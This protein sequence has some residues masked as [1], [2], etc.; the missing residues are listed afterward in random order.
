MIDFQ[1]KI[2]RITAMSR[3][4]GFAKALGFEL[5][6]SLRSP[7][8]PL[9]V[10]GYPAG[11]TIR[12]NNSDSFVFSSIF[13]EGELSAYVPTEPRLIIDGGANVGFSTAYFAQHYP[14]AAVV[15]VEPSGENCAR[16][17]RHCAGFGNVTLLEGGLWSQSGLLRIVNPEDASWSFRCEPADGPGEGVF[18]A[19][20]IGEIIDRSGADRCDLLKLDI[21]GAEASVFAPGA[22]DW[23]DRVDAILVEVHGDEALANITAACPETLFDSSRNGEKLV[24]IRNG[25]SNQ[26]AAEVPGTHTRLG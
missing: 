3:L 1:A 4:V 13:L 15:A 26:G 9:Q 5:A 22:L 19:F 16:I 14:S 24:L 8:V 12:R 25:R 7:E 20:T 18:T 23:L 2:N 21:E 11:F 6:W 17:K 10:P